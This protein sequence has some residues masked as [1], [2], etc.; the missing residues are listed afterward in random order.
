MMSMPPFRRPAAGVERLAVLGYSSRDGSTIYSDQDNMKLETDLKRINKLSM[1]EEER[2]RAFSSY[3]EDGALSARKL[4]SLV[5]AL[6]DEVTSQI[7]CGTCANCCVEGYPILKEADVQRLALFLNLSQD[8]F[9]STYLQRDAEKKT[10]TF[11]LMPCPFLHDNRCE[12]YAARPEDCRSF[13]HLHKPDFLSR[14]NRVIDN[15]AMCPVVFNVYE[16]LKQNLWRGR[17]ENRK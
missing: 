10:D 12:V 3:L 2:N 13:P 5:H 15:C 9:R 14:L 1:R 16:R 7:D 11:T 4:D 8:D 17:H 6:N